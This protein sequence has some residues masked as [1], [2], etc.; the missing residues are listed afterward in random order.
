MPGGA[1]GVSVQQQFQR[2][3]VGSSSDS[4]STCKLQFLLRET[5]LHKMKD[6]FVK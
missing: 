4:A 1:E 6:F 3:V 5:I 2:G